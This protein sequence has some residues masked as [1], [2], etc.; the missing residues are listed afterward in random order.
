MK[1]N[2]LIIDTFNFSSRAYHVC[3]TNTK[4]KEDLVKDTIV[5][6]FRMLK[7]VENNFLLPGGK[8]YFLFDNSTSIEDRRKEIDP[9]YKST[10]RKKDEAFIRLVDILQLVLASYKDNYFYIRME[11]LEAD[12]LVYPLLS[13]IEKED[14]NY[15]LISNDLDWSRCITEN[16]HQ[17]IY[18]GKDY[19]IRTITKF[20]EKFGFS[21]LKNNIQLYKSFRGDEIDSIPKGVSGIKTTDLLKIIQSCSSLKE[22][23]KS[24]DTIDISNTWKNKIRENWARL[25][26][27]YRLV[28]FIKIEES[29]LKESLYESSFNALALK[30]LYGSIGLPDNFDV[31]IEQLYPKKSNKNFF[32][33]EKIPRQGY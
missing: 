26:L 10:R 7:K 24:L 1:Y 22:L 15:L 28:D 19:T 11:N 17:A 30:V 4:L 16:T 14:E 18:S 5:L 21:P 3:L 23:Y 6:F 12:D 33:Y 31:R 29:D 27:N 8:V 9:S 13:I 32:N 25:S 20:K 2:S